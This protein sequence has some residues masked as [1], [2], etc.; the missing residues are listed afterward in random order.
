MKQ[1]VNSL[2]TAL[3]RNRTPGGVRGRVFRGPPTRFKY[4]S[5]FFSINKFLAIGALIFIPMLKA[6]DTQKRAIPLLIR[7]ILETHLQ[8]SKMPWLIKVFSDRPFD[9]LSLEKLMSETTSVA[10]EEFFRN[11]KL[12]YIDD[13]GSYEYWDKTSYQSAQEFILQ[14]LQDQVA[15]S[16]DS[17]WNSYWERLTPNK[18]EYFSFYIVQQ[19]IEAFDAPGHPSHQDWTKIPYFQ[20]S[21]QFNLFYFEN[22]KRQYQSLYSFLSD[23]LFANTE[24]LLNIKKQVIAFIKVLFRTDIVRSQNF[25]LRSLFVDKFKS[26]TDKLTP[27]E[28][29]YLILFIKRELKK[30]LTP[31]EL[32]NPKL[33]A[34]KN[35]SNTKF[36]Q[37]NPNLPQENKQYPIKTIE[38]SE[39]E[40]LFQLIE[41]YESLD[42]DNPNLEQNEIKKFFETDIK[43]IN[44]SNDDSGFSPNKK[45]LLEFI[46][47]E[48]ARLIETT[49]FLLNDLKLKEFID[50]LSKARIFKKK[51][52]KRYF[53]DS[54]LNDIWPIVCRNREFLRTLNYD[55]KPMMNKLDFIIHL[56]K[57]KTIIISPERVNSF[58]TSFFIN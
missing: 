41:F 3:V 30:I 7:Q 39:L 17:I 28:N 24:Y 18:K 55:L 37:E 36:Y 4:L 40:F 42:L 2:S 44:H 49:D 34:V 45:V 9:P 21:D 8:H 16:I 29:I 47:M 43:F 31:E 52:S 12:K 35:N 50:K 51:E 48:L 1:F 25:H 10:I 15:E 22:Q 20:I 27:L 26:Y 54:Y 33:F 14:S 11:L 32:L 19:V 46:C 53:I 5:F 56:D 57:L 23:V 58:E 6:Q 38:E 13:L